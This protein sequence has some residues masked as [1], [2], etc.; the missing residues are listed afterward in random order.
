MAN[1]IVTQQVLDERLLLEAVDE[2]CKR[3]TDLAGVIESYGPPPLW[4][5]EAGFATLIHIILEQQVSL[6]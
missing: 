6:A 1:N 3:D 2:L 5:R 4:A